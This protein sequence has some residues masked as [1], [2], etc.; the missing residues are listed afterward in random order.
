MARGEVRI[1]SAKPIV[2]TQS[3]V[4]GAVFSTFSIPLED[5]GRSKFRNVNFQAEKFQPLL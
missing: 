1:Y 2:A 3:V 5:G 4:R